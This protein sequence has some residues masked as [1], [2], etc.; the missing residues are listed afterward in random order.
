M[1]NQQH[2]VIDYLN[3]NDGLLIEIYIYIYIYEIALKN[4]KREYQN[5]IGNKLKIYARAFF[6]YIHTLYYICVFIIYIYF[7]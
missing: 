5:E 4:L 1:S 2:D 7:M 6:S 3:N